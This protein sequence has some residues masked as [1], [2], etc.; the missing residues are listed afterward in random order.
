MPEDMARALGASGPLTITIADKECQVR[1]LGVRE[2]TE[3]ERDCL[4]RYRRS[5]IKTFV[6]NA[7]LMPNG[8]MVLVEKMETAARWDIGDLP[9][10]TAYSVDHVK[11]SGELRDFL[12]EIFSLKK[13]PTKAEKRKMSSQEYATLLKESKLTDERWRRL[14]VN[15]LDNGTL[16]P[17]KFEELAGALPVKGSIPYVN[18]WITGCFEGMITFCWVAF[19]LN[20]V[21]REQVADALTDRPA[22]LVELSREIEKLSAPQAGNG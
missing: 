17:E 13:P 21:S 12:Q 20:G 15:S 11:V 9:P 19:K 7:D 8:Q 22:M 10:K 18:W 16:S 5:Y 1:P 14:A 6:D 2:L 3:A 4:E